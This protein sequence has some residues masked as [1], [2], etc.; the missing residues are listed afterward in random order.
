MRG[1]IKMVDYLDTMAWDIAISA[2][3]VGVA[4]LRLRYKTSSDSVEPDDKNLRMGLGA[5][6]GLSGF[7]LFLSGIGITF[8][9][10]FPAH[11]NVLFGGVATLGGLALLATSAA[12]FLNAGLKEVSYFAAVVGLYLVVSAIGI[13]NYGLTRADGRLLAFLSYLV[14]AIAS[15]LT[16]PATHS[17]NKYFRWL[18]AIFAFLFALAWLV[19]AGLFTRGHLEPPA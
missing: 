15:F 11:Y 14:S 3:L 9:A 16:V 8:M 1:L 10:T 5:G 2:I 18:F 19:E 17:D 7:Y 6:I 4:A 13:M 12:L